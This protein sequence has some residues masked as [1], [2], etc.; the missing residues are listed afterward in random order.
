MIPVILHRCSR[1]RRYA[2]GSFSGERVAS[3]CFGLISSKYN[4]DTD[5]LRS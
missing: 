2:V 1:K 5:A 3:G 4:A